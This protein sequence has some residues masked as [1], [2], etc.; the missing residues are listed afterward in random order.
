MSFT[1][2]VMSL[3]AVLMLVACAGTP[4]NNNDETRA[5]AKEAY[6]ELDE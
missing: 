1:K 5:N 4:E 6:Q 2:V 3:F